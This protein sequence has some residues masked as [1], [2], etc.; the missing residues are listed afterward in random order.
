MAL[1]LALIEEFW[2][3]DE[4]S[5]LHSCQTRFPGAQGTVAGLGSGGISPTFVRTQNLTLN[6][7]LPLNIHLNLT[8]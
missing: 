5:K 3:V 1:I 6:L 7:D 8:C 2:S 4:K